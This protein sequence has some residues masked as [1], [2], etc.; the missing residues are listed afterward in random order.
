MSRLILTAIAGASLLLGGPAVAQRAADGTTAEERAN[1]AALNKAQADRAAAEIAAYSAQLS[2]VAAQD[3]AAKAEFSSQTAAY[4][5][6]KARIA[7][8]SAEELVQ[9]EADVA[10]CKGGDTGRCAPATPQP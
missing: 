6:E 3:A 9:W 1:T 7:A 5:A 4:E 2:G 8:M 10:A